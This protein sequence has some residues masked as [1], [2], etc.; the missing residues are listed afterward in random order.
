M[1]VFVPKNGMFEQAHG[2]KGLGAQ[3]M[4]PMGHGYPIAKRGGTRALALGDLLGKLGIDTAALDGALGEIS[5][6][7]LLRRRLNAVEEQGTAKER[8]Y[9]VRLR[10]VALSTLRIALTSLVS[11]KKSA[12]RTGTG[13][14]TLS[15]TVVNT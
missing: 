14:L 15:G 13:N 6:N 2:N 3:G 7:G 12:S 10:S 1:A 9:G 11:K 8:A 4:H 5:E